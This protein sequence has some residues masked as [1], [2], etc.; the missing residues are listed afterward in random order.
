MFVITFGTGFQMKF[1]NGWIVSVQ[2]GPSNYSDARKI[3][4][5]PGFNPDFSRANQ[6]PPEGSE[7]KS[8]EVAIIQPDGK[9]F[10]APGTGD[11]MMGW[12]DADQVAAIINWTAGRPANMIGAVDNFPEAR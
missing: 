8:A 5:R 2:F 9:F 12:V 7:I 4:Q 3:G 1:A 11:G 10:V 6:Y